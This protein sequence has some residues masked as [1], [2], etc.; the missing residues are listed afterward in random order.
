MAIAPVAGR[1]ASAFNPAGTVLN[2]VLPAAPGLGNLVVVGVVNGGGAIN[3]TAADSN[4]NVYT[5]TPASGVIFAGGFARAWVFYLKSAPAN[6]SATIRLT[7]S[8]ATDITGH[9]AE[10]TGQDKIAPID[11]EA[12][13]FSATSSTNIND[14][15]ITPNFDGD[16]L[17][18][19][20][21]ANIS[22][23][24]SPWTGIG[25]IVNGNYAEYLIQGT[26][27]ARAI[28]FTQ[29]ASAWLA[30]ATAFKAASSASVGTAAGTSTVAGVGASD[31]PAS[32]TSAGAG[33]A[34]GAAAADSSTAGSSAGAGG[35]TGVGAVVAPYRVK[36]GT[37]T[38]PGSASITDDTANLPQQFLNINFPTG[39][40][41]GSSI[42][43]M[44]DTYGATGNGST[45]DR[46]AFAALGSGGAVVPPGTYRIASNLTIN[47]HLY[48]M[49]GAQLRP[50]SGVQI[51]MGVGSSIIAGPYQIFDNSLGGSFSNGANMSGWANAQWFPGSGS[52]KDL[53]QQLNTGVNWGFRLFELLNNPGLEIRTTVR[54]PHSFHLKLAYNMYPQQINLK[55]SNKPVFEATDNDIRHF[56]IQGG[57]WKGSFTQTPSCFL[58]VS[59]NSTG[60]QTGDCVVMDTCHIE[61]AFGV[62]VIVHIGAEVCTYKDCLISQGSTGDSPWGGPKA[63][64]MMGFAD[65][66]N[67]PFAY[68][69][70]N[71]QGRSTSANVFDNCTVGGDIQGVNSCYLLKGQ[72]EDTKITG[73]YLNS[74]GRAH[75][76]FEPGQD[77]SGNWTG[78]RRVSLCGGG[79]TETNNGTIWA[80]VPVVLVD[81]L[82]QG[83]GVH[84]LSIADIGIFIGA[85]SHTTP[86]I[87]CINGGTLDG[88]AM[89]QGVY[90]EP[91][92]NKL[93]DNT[94]SDM[95]DVEISVPLNMDITCTGRTF[96]N[97]YI[98]TKG[99]IFGTVA[100]SS[101][102]RAANFNNW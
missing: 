14:P 66:W 12:T 100:A 6:A 92:S 63:T 54:V 86:M 16:L 34:N 9:A 30:I 102:V 74:L 43:N 79:R 35:G 84:M 69:Q 83:R 53:G 36:I 5:A 3:M 19:I 24:N 48:F 8:S 99:N 88:L 55:T 38:G 93:I 60:T 28:S 61:G 50:A 80:G 94:V 98:R 77:S 13:H 95:N 76:V 90:I 56:T 97:C 33:A 25:S 32:G 11:V 23:A 26:K 37:I 87:R 70:P 20:C 41:G 75:I 78:P 42:P 46:G 31:L 71:R 45:D 2:V 68:T 58:L 22:S 29:S 73:V 27:A 52:P 51:S 65:Y 21:A 47:G 67:V 40:G 17:F 72:V 7:A 96:N 49:A 1:T 62:G 59:S 15:T 18:S 64:V 4:G 57:S 10:F 82:N 85:G 44:K 91:N 101:R 39:G 81:G 89:R